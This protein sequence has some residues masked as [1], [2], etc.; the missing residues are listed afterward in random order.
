[1]VTTYKVSNKSENPKCVIYC[2]HSHI[3]WIRTRRT[4]E[5]LWESSLQ[6]SIKV[7]PPLSDVHFFRELAA[8]YL[9]CQR[10][11]QCAL[12][13]NGRIAFLLAFG[14]PKPVFRRHEA[15]WNGGKVSCH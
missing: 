13:A 7:L 2:Q 8:E 1:M 6:I 4:E 14:L 3:R 5:W 12:L 10:V 15:F 9:P 11:K